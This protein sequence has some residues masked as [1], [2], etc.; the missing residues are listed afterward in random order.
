MASVRCLAAFL[1]AIEIS[2]TSGLQGA[3]WSERGLQPQFTGAQAKLR[4]AVMPPAR[5]DSLAR[6]V[7]LGRLKDGDCA[8]S[9]STTKAGVIRPRGWRTVAPQPVTRVVMALTHSGHPQRDCT[10]SLL[11]RRRPHW[12]PRLPRKSPA[13]CRRPCCLGASD[14][15][16]FALRPAIVRNW[17]GKSRCSPPLAAGAAVDLL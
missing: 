5:K 14:Y 6:G 4:R 15:T 3:A 17:S 2:V 9:T 1:K 7:P 10:C 13:L 12:K 16:A 8:S 11:R